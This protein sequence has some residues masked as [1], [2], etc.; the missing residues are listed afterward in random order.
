MAKKLGDF[1][2]PTKNELFT[3]SKWLRGERPNG[4]QR[5]NSFNGM[6]I[7]RWDRG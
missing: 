6:E 3:R 5:G 2:A 7:D 4:S 1:I